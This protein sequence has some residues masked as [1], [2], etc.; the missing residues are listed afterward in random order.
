MFFDSKSINGVRQKCFLFF[1]LFIS[2]LL[3]FI[4]LIFFYNF[5]YYFI[6]IIKIDILNL[7]SIFIIFL[8]FVVFYFYIIFFNRYIKIFF[9]FYFITFCIRRGLYFYRLGYFKPNNNYNFLEDRYSILLGKKEINTIDNIFILYY[10]KNKNDT[11]VNFTNLAFILTNFRDFNYY[12]H[13][14]SFDKNYIFNCY[15]FFY[16]FYQIF[17]LLN[18]NVSFS[19]YNVR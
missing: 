16:D 3:I 12:D 9:V 18:L 1:K 14:A 10:Y 11:L 13:L 8:Y 2:S 7:I 6:K 17:N 5:I 19:I 15:Y 4:C